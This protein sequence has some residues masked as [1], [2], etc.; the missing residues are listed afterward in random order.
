MPLEQFYLKLELHWRCLTTNFL[1]S[2]GNKLVFLVKMVTHRK[3]LSTLRLFGL[4]NKNTRGPV[5]FEVQIKK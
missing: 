4:A 5:T 1:L 3:R 2:M